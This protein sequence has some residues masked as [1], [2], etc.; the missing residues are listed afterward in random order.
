MRQV[1]SHRRQMTP[2][3]NNLPVSQKPSQNGPAPISRNSPV[4]PRNTTP[5]NYRSLDGY[6]IVNGTTILPATGGLDVGQL[7]VSSTGN[8][9]NGP[10]Q[11]N[12]SGIQVGSLNL[13][14][15]G[16]LAV[17]SVNVSGTG[18]RVGPLNLSLDGSINSSSLKISSTEL[19]I[20]LAAIKDG[21]LSGVTLDDSI[22][23]KTS[24]VTGVPSTVIGSQL[25]QYGSELVSQGLEITPKLDK[26]LGQQLLTLDFVRGPVR[27]MSVLTPIMTPGGFIESPITPKYNTGMMTVPNP[28]LSSTTPLF[29]RAL[30]WA[31]DQEPNQESQPA[32]WGGWIDCTVWISSETLSISYVEQITTDVVHN[33][34][35]SRVSC[36]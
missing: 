12:G 10:V 36:Q 23:I 35:W 24:S 9:S 3:K 31:Q 22:K 33:T 30:L 17:G 8:L 4:P 29:G 28:G 21:V 18:V 26:L 15:D 34:R 27:G 2:R 32:F 11:V 6:Q 14:S 5:S 19:K 13:N 7:H 1:A 16:N 25:V 20:G